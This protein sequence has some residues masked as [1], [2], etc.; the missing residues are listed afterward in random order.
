MRIFP[1]L[2]LFWT[3]SDFGRCRTM[4]FWKNKMLSCSKLETMFK[5]QN[6]KEDEGLKSWKKGAQN[7]EM[8]IKWLFLNRFH[9][10]LDC[11]VHL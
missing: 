9:S 2:S 6:A 10:R 5:Y 3:K 8:S 7:I 11:D 4:F 1:E